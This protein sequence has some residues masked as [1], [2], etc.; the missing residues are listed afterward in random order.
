[1]WEVI[2]ANKRRAVV[3]IIGMAALL[4]AVGFVLGELVAPGPAFLAC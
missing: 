4:M 1:M 2:R 3:L